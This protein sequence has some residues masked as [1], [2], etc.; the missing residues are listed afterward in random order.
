METLSQCL[1]DYLEAIYIINL[2]RKVVRVK[3]VAEFLNVKN[4]SV[5]DAISKL[6][7]KGF[8]THEKYG[9]LNLTAKGVESAKGVYKKHGDIY[10]FLNKVLGMDNETSE[11]DACGIE[12]YI[13]RKTLDKIVKLME[14]LEKSPEGYPEWLANFNHFVAHGKRLES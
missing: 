6:A 13:S 4:P 14:F 2:N 12:H 3:E 11:K 8:V 9:Y 7:E 10:K 1:E 5:V